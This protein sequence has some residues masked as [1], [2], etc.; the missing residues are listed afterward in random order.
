M[1]VSTVS[2]VPPGRRSVQQADQ[3][4]IALRHFAARYIGARRAGGELR[5]R[6]VALL[7]ER[8]LATADHEEIDRV[9]GTIERSAQVAD[10]RTRA[11]EAVI[12]AVARHIDVTQLQTV[13]QPPGAGS[14]VVYRPPDA[15]LR[16]GWS[17]PDETG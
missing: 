15:V 14:P 3:V 10:D 1:T 4:K 7:H 12:A 13:A 16:G 5:T 9:R 2:T 17:P 11:L 6:L 8:K